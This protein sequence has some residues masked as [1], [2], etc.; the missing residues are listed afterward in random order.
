MSVEKSREKISKLVK[1]V[2]AAQIV[3]LEAYGGSNV[4]YMRANK[5]IIGLMIATDEVKDVNLLILEQLKEINEKLTP[6]TETI[7]EEIDENPIEEEVKK[8]AGRPSKTDK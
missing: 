7:E 4:E 8:K 2:G 3:A 5:E 6:V 1:M